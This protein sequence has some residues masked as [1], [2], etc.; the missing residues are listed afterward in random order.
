M[1]GLTEEVAEVV[2]GDVRRLPLL[3]SAPQAALDDIAAT[4][5]PLSVS[6]SALVRVLE[7]WRRGD[8]G[9]DEVQQ[10]AS[11]VRRGYVAGKA[12]GPLRPIEIAYDASDEALIAEIIGRFDEIG[13][14]IDGHLEETEQFEMLRALRR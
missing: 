5:P 7:A 6:C 2:A 14:L 3:L 8:C 9:A 10:W 1:S 13:D 11:F 4:R 12:A